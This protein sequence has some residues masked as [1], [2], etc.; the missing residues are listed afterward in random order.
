MGQPGRGV[1][2]LGGTCTRCTRLK[3]LLRRVGCSVACL[4]WRVGRIAYS[5][6]LFSAGRGLLLVLETSA[7]K[8]AR[9]CS[10]LLR[11]TPRLF[12]S[13]ALRGLRCGL[14][15]NP[16]L[17]LVTRQR[18]GKGE[19]AGA[20]TSRSTLGKTCWTSSHNLYSKGCHQWHSYLSGIFARQV[21]LCPLDW[22]QGLGTRSIPK[23][24]PKP[25]W[26]RNASGSREDPSGS[27][28]RWR[29]FR[30]RMGE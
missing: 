21:F 27:R 11:K 30:A 8:E 2:R 6:A 13:E 17:P 26:Q 20:A 16:A 10:E 25:Q 24:A 19:T 7:A 15:G 4:A 3:C 14:S 23:S 9:R 12:L 22:L 29:T 1:L 5:G 28:K 18:G